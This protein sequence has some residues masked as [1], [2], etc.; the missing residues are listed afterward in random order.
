MKLDDVPDKP[1]FFP[2][3]MASNGVIPFFFPALQSR[4]DRR[5]SG[6]CTARGTEDAGSQLPGDRTI[7][8]RF[9][10]ASNVSNFH[11]S[12]THR[13][14]V[15]CIYAN[16]WSILMVNLTI[17]SLHGS[18]GIVDLP[19]KNRG[20]FHSYVNVCQRLLPYHCQIFYCIQPCGSGP[21]SEAGYGEAGYG[22]CPGLGQVCGRPVG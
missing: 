20:S 15:W 4:R 17:Y 7:Q 12:H 16:I 6:R 11:Q 21:C 9:D 1:R 10:K 8:A 19:I 14:H 13:I 18:Y 5:L 2:H 3:A 22:W